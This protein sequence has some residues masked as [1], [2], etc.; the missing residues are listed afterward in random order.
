M[1]HRSFYQGAT[2]PHCSATLSGH[3]AVSAD[4]RPKPGDVS[5]CAYCAEI[6][7]YDDTG[8]L[9]IPSP[10]LLLELSALPDVARARQIVLQVIRKNGRRA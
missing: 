4:A 1:K 8:Q 7:Q 10:E 2:C 6:N 3:M 5:I 9:V